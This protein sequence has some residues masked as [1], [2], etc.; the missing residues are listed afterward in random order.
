MEKPALIFLIY[1]REDIETVKEIHQKLSNAGFNPWMDKKD[2][3]PGQRWRQEIPKALR[4]S[5]F[6]LAFFSRISVAKQGFVQEEFKLALD[7]LK[8]IPEGKIHTIPVRLDDCIIPEPFSDLQCADLFE[9]DQ[10][11]RIVQAIRTELSQQSTEPESDSDSVEGTLPTAHHKSTSKNPTTVLSRRKSRSRNRADFARKSLEIAHLAIGEFCRSYQA[12][13]MGL[14]LE[15][16]EI[17]E[18]SSY[19]PD[20]DLLISPHEYYIASWVGIGESI[21]SKIYKSMC[22]IH[23]EMAREI[24]FSSGKIKASCYVAINGEEYSKTS[25]DIESLKSFIFNKNSK[26]IADFIQIKSIFFSITT[27]LIERDNQQKNFAYAVSFNSFFK[28]P[29][30]LYKIYNISN[31][32]G[33]NIPEKSAFVSS[34]DSIVE[35]FPDWHTIGDYKENM[36][37]LFDD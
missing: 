15:G 1:A 4:S 8:Q 21:P 32:N 2:L 31:R 33:E 18:V 30:T 16:L 14:F 23:R 26:I 37:E 12:D 35:R 3:L 29:E 10:F 27:N 25:Q 13:R 19:V 5:D 28:M 22:H 34:L 11:E 6:I 36:N 9:D 20:G 17:M 24:N 7:T